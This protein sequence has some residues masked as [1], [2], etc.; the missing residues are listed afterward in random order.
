M[1]QS[2]PRRKFADIAHVFPTR[3]RYLIARVAFGSTTPVMLG[4]LLLTQSVI[5][6]AL[7]F[8]ICMSITTICWLAPYNASSSRP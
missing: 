1:L 6:A 8:I 3:E 7:G 5:G 4:I 2:K